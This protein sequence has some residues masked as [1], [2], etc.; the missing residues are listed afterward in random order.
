MQRGGSRGADPHGGGEWMFL[1]R[2]CACLSA[3]W[4]SLSQEGGVSDSAQHGA[5]V[6]P[7]SL[8]ARWKIRYLLFYVLFFSAEPDFAEQD[9]W[10]VTKADAGQLFPI[11]WSG[12][13]VLV[14]WSC[15]TL[16]EPAQILT[17]FFIVWSNCDKTQWEKKP[18]PSQ[19]LEKGSGLVYLHRALKTTKVNNPGLLSIRTGKPVHV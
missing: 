14:I 16:K 10:S 3:L 8:E 1:C 4:G 17:F 13:S 19:V 12:W 18:S 9:V 5:L 11:Q 7:T 6:R 2:W 15:E